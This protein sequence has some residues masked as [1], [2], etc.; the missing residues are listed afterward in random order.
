[1][2]NPVEEVTGVVH[3]LTQGSPDEQTEAIN[4]YFTPNA[5][6]THPFCR[7]GS[8]E[9]SR[10]LI[11]AIYKWYKIL[12]PKISEMNVNSVGMYNSS[13]QSRISVVAMR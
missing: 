3:Q 8:F 10:N 5:S 13:S 12:S 4:A 7:T 6:F 11:H 1:M 9:G 2:D